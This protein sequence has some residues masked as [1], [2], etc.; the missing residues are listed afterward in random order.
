MNSASQSEPKDKKY[1]LESLSNYIS[2]L[3]KLGGLPLVLIGLGAANLF[4]PG[5]PLYTEAKQILMT[6]LLFCSALIVWGS[7]TL[8]AYKRWKFEMQIASQ[9]DA[10]IINAITT[11]VEKT[12]SDAAAKQRVETLVSQLPALRSRAVPPLALPDAKT[13]EH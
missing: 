13:N 10:T 9:Q 7:V 2:G 11:I 8:L 3:W 4:I 1:R 6:T 12:K 5:N